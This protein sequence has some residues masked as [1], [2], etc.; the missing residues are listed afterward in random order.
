ML[1]QLVASSEEQEMATEN[2]CHRYFL[3]L[4]ELMRIQERG[5]C[6]ATTG[7]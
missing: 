2:G 3:W 5:S 4:L 6:E 1:F 7:T